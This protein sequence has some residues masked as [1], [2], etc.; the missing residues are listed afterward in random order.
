[1]QPGDFP[2]PGEFAL[3][4][5][6]DAH[7]ELE[8]W[9]RNVGAPVALDLAPAPAQTIASVDVVSWNVAI[10]AGDLERTVAALRRVGLGT[11]ER[12]LVLLLQ[13]AYRADET[14]PALPLS[15]HHGGKAGIAG[16]QDIVA[17]ARALGFSLR[18]APSMRNGASRSD[19]G[20]AILSS[21]PLD[22]AHGFQ[23]PHV[24]QRRVAVAASLHGLAEL[25]LV[26]AHLD[27]RGQPRG[28][29]RLGRFGAGRVV[30]AAG[31][32]QRLSHAH[33]RRTILLGADLNT[34]LGDRD[35][36]LEAMR[37]AG[38]RSPPRRG[39][40]HSFAGPVRLLLD[41]ILL[42]T[43]E[44][45]ARVDALHRLDDEEAGRRVFGSDHYP[46]FT[47]VELE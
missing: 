15:M 25:T 6:D 30:Q 43:L 23:L 27:T 5:D 34:Y 41:H 4:A 38:F 13:E 29:R 47:R 2:V 31:L 24:R 20:N 22:E 35:P 19:R 8:H 45:R 9:Q 18:Y 36:A 40:T 42:R 1:M 16:R 46:L 3:L 44:D 21:A 12:P 10:G 17:A 26:S 7:P 14:V 39:W 11:G 32:A 33:E 37:I 28:R